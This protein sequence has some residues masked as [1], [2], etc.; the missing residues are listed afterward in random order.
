[1]QR[2]KSFPLSFEPPIESL[3]GRLRKLGK[4]ARETAMTIVPSIKQ[5]GYFSESKK[6]YYS[7]LFSIQFPLL[8]NVLDGNDSGDISNK[9]IYLL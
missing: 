9:Y 1:M 3:G 8:K 7:S 5:A 4:P 2:T 6:S